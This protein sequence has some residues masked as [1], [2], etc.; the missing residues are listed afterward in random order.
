MGH[1]GDVVFYASVIVVVILVRLSR[2]VGRRWCFFFTACIAC[3]K[4]NNNKCTGPIRMKNNTKKAKSAASVINATTQQ[5]QLSINNNWQSHSDNSIN[6]EMESGTLP[7]PT[8]LLHSNESIQHLSSSDSPMNPYSDLFSSRQSIPI[9]NKTNKRKIDELVDPSSTDFDSSSLKP[10]KIEQVDSERSLSRTGTPLSNGP[11]PQQSSSTPSRNGNDNGSSY[12]FGPPSNNNNTGSTTPNPSLLTQ[13]TPPPPS[14][15]QQQQQILH[16]QPPVSSYM[17]MSPRNQYIITSDSPFLQANNQVFVFTTQLANEAAEAVLKNECPNIIEYHKSLPSTAQYLA[18]LSNNMNNSHNSLLGGPMHMNHGLPPPPP[19]GCHSPRTMQMMMG[20]PVPHNPHLPHHNGN[21]GP[22]PNWSHPHFHPHQQQPPFGRLTPGPGGLPPPSHLLPPG[23][24]I[25]NGQPPSDGIENLTPERAKHRKNQLNKIEDL[26]TKITGGRNRGRGKANA[27]ANAAAAA[28][29]A[30]GNMPSSINGGP[31][32]PGALDPHQ[33]QM[34]MM[35]SPHGVG[36]PHHMMGIGPPPPHML[37]PG[38]RGPDGMMLDMNGPPPPPPHGY[39]NGPMPPNFHGQYGP[40]PGDPYGQLPPPP[41]QQSQAVRDWT[42]M[43]MEHIEGKVQ[44][45]RGQPPPYSSAS[46]SSLTPP[47]A[48]TSTGGGLG[49]N[50]KLLSPKME[51]STTPRLYKVGQPEKFI[52][53][54]LPSSAN[55]KI[56]GNVGEVQLTASPTQMDYNELGMEGEEL[57]ITRHLNRAYRAANGINNGPPLPSSSSSSCKD[58]PMTPITRS[59]STPNT[60]TNSLSSGQQQQQSVGSTTP[61]HLSQQG[62]SSHLTSQNVSAA[63]PRPAKLTA[64]SSLSSPLMLSNNTSLTK[65][66]PLD[67]HNGPKTPT[68]NMAPPLSSMLQMTNNL[69][70]ANSPY[71]SSNNTGSKSSLSSNLTSNGPSLTNPNIPHMSKSMDHLPSP[72]HMSLP[73]HQQHM[74]F[75]NMNPHHRML[76]PPESMSPH[77]NPHH[78]GNL[79]PPPPHPHMYKMMPPHHTLDPSGMMLSHPGG[80]PRSSKGLPPP[81]SDPMQQHHHLA[82]P[83]HYMK[84]HNMDPLLGPPPGHQQQ[85]MRFVPMMDDSFCMGPP[86]PSHHP[87]HP[88]MH[89]HMHPHPQM[90]HHPMH[91]NDGRPPPPPPQSINNTYVSTTMSIQQLNIQSVGPGG[92]PPELQPGTIHYHASSA[93]GPDSQQQ[94]QQQ[95]LSGS[96][97]NSTM[98]SS[99]QQQFATMNAMSTND[100]TFASQFNDL[101]LPPSN[102]SVDGGQPPSYW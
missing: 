18:S 88:H 95:G 74:Q 32:P 28:A 25:M 29:A 64:N 26:K 101:Q 31:L 66:E 39:M 56:T 80:P 20:G 83:P 11:L 61:T 52:P 6:N 45:M 68:S 49:P 67:M 57:I 91:P 69:Q 23:A 94:Q 48:T 96:N 2:D 41:H 47:I 19:P 79:P 84:M 86:P 97:G 46:P 90:H 53:D 44:Q 82:P 35:N 58:E 14:L 93:S 85:H 60:N 92:P 59:N 16:S 30:A 102:L 98:F 77:Y 75:Q 8:M 21:G 54:S 38:M 3:S 5:Q 99:Q 71:N 50:G 76:G 10:Q 27:A 1:S 40:G 15:Q 34:M 22:P 4:W 81:S 87:H 63:S 12:D 36:P 24:L 37:H 70:S 7:P 89:P 17:S 13:Q 43:Q 42:K 51:P 78:G 9:N 55:K 62:S 33:Q 100:P 73:P 72:S 65:D